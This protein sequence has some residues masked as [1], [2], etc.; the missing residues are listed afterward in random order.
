M[1][2]EAFCGYDHSA[3]VLKG[4][5]RYAWVGAGMKYLQRTGIER[6]ARITEQ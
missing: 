4:E 1:W 2:M 6:E 3:A 5:M